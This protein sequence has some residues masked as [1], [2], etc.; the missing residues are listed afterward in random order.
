[1]PV[2]TIFSDFLGVKQDVVPFGTQ[3]RLGRSIYLIRDSD[4]QAAHVSAGV[5]SALHF[6]LGV[7]T[8]F[9]HGL[10]IRMKTTK[11]LSIN[12]SA[13]RDSGFQTVYTATVQPIVVSN[14]LYFST[15]FAYDGES[16][17]LIEISYTNPIDGSNDQVL[18]GAERYPCSISTSSSESALA[19][20]GSE[21]ISINPINFN[22]ISNE[23]TISAWTNGDTS[24]LPANS[25]L[26]EG[27][28][29][30]GHR[31]VNAHL[32]WS[33]GNVYWDCGADGAWELR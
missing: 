4:L 6:Q 16:G 17:I 18:S 23:I 7:G 10:T 32:P 12:E 22:R 25:A 15:P 27:A 30:L 33:D 11:L 14:I 19:F 9:L 2:T 1:M 28:D 24:V 20:S 8:T 3:S 13:T 5:I 21:G 29:E 31:Q 26:F